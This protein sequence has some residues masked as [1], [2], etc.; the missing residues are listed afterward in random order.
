[1]KEKKSM[2]G[3]NVS[4]FIKG[5]FGLGEGVRSNIR[6]IKAANVPYCVNDLNMN[7]PKYISNADNIDEQLKSTNDYAINLIQVN[8]DMIP[9][10]V[11]SVGTRYFEGK[12]NIGFWAWELENFPEASKTFF[13]LFNEIW[14]PSNFCAEAIS[15]ISPVP[16]LKFMHSIEI[17]EPKFDRETFNLP[18]EKF[19]FLTIF[20]YYSSIDRKNPIAVI[21]AY[22]KAFGRNNPDVL[23]VIKSS[24]SKEFPKDK[25]IL[26]D[27]ID[28]NSSII[29]IEEIL[30]KEHLY[31]LMNC[32]DCFVS[33]HCSEG[34]GLTMA[35]AMYLEKPVIGTAYSSNV[36]F[37]NNANSY[38]VNYSLVRT[39]SN[40]YYSNN[41]DYWADADTEHAAQLMMDVFHNP[42][43]TLK[44]AKQAKIDAHTVLSP[45]VIG[46]KIKNRIDLIYNDIIPNQSETKDRVSL[47]EFENKFL[48]QKLDR[49]RSYAPIKMKLAFKNFKNKLLGKNKKY[50]WED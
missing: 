39:P 33:L 27:K 23:L 41:S 25:R 3:V 18:Q 29:L 24:I 26:M 19:I 20:D 5:Q 34:F 31:S 42:E 49:L 46:N 7:L 36:E 4:G 47:L 6:S 48:Q 11:E 30:E 1:M 15:K 40:F 32:C 14:V 17:P 8:M 37:M 28:N 43:K 13:P 9:K 38:L 44:I 35:E 45:E 21:D 2:Y 12:Y 16:V 22:V 10:V 50:I